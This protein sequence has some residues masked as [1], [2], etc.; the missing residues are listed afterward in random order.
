LN[1]L[2]K[3]VRAQCDKARQ[4]FHASSLSSRFVFATAKLK[5]F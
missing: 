5:H 2:Y 4:T 1:I 3:P